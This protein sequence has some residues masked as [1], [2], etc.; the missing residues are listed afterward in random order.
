MPEEL[1]PFAVN[2]SHIHQ[3]IKQQC[4]EFSEQAQHDFFTH[5]AHTESKRKREPFSPLL[6]LVTINTSLFRRNSLIKHLYFASGFVF[7]SEQLYLDGEIG[8]F[9]CF[10]TLCTTK[11]KF[12][13]HEDC[14]LFIKMAQKS[15]F[16]LTL[17]F[18]LLKGE[19][20]GRKNFNWGCA[21]HKCKTVSSRQNLNLHWQIF[22]FYLRF[23]VFPF[24]NIHTTDE[25][26]TPCVHRALRDCRVS[27]ALLLLYIF[28]CTQIHTPSLKQTRRKHE[29]RQGED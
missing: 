17:F 1:P 4:R 9:T 18:F 10:S 15:I 7:L 29:G 11:G 12:T 25:G 28:Q 26:K 13:L 20:S 5:R 16:F 27:A 8:D 3:H 21:N 22:L 2:G 23:A 19:E 24:T 14:E 6:F